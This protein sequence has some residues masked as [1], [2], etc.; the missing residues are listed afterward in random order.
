MITTVNP[1]SDLGDVLMEDEEEEKDS[2]VQKDGFARQDVFTRLSS[3]QNRFST[4]SIDKKHSFFMTRKSSE[5]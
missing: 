4:R 1:V 2:P 3:N 5:G